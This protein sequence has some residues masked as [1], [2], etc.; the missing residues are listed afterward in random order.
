[1]FWVFL[2]FLVSGMPGSPGGRVPVYIFSKQN[3]DLGFL[4]FLVVLVL[5]AFLVFVVFLV[6]LVLLVFL[7]ISLVFGVVL[8][9][10]ARCFWKFWSLQVGRRDGERGGVAAASVAAGSAAAGASRWR[11]YSWYFCLVSAISL[12]RKWCGV[13]VGKATSAN[14]CGNWSDL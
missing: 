9:I 6:L 1:M 13:V 8:G 3:G 4:V 10:F 12:E 7:V 11:G 2:V 14:R 5:L